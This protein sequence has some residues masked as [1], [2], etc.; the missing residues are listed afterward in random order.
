MTASAVTSANDRSTFY[1]KTNSSG[2][3]IALNLRKQAFS[4]AGLRT[5]LGID[6]AKPTG[7]L[8]GNSKAEALESGCVPVVL[9]YKSARGRL[10]TA[11]VLCSPSTADTVFTTARGKK[12]AGREIETVR[13]PRRRVYVF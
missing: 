7:S 11:K 13:F 3:H 10:Q 9:V 2:D 4:D 6:T 12:Y 1:I 8:V 5:A